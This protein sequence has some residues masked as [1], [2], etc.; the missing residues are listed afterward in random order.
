MTELEVIKPSED[1]V[2]IITEP[3]RFANLR[4]AA[5]IDQDVNLNQYTLIPNEGRW[6]LAPTAEH[7]R[8]LWADNGPVP[9]S[10]TAEDNICALT[11][12]P[13]N[14]VQSMPTNLQ[15]GVTVWA[16]REKLSREQNKLRLTTLSPNGH[17]NDWRL[18]AILSQR[19]N[20]IDDYQILGVFDEVLQDY[21][22][23]KLERWEIQDRFTRLSVTFDNIDLGDSEGRRGITLSNSEV[24]CASVSVDSFIWRLVCSNGL[25][26]KTKDTSYRFIHIGGKDNTENLR[27]AIYAS[28][29]NSESVIDAYRKATTIA[30]KDPAE[31]LRQFAITNKL[32]QRMLD[33]FSETFAMEERNT[34]SGIVNAI[35]RRAQAEQDELNRHNLEALAGKY[36]IDRVARIAS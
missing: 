15:T 23:A 10:R 4:A 28:L 9:L 12:M 29:Q 17:A 13:R 19:Y 30:L 34:V 11:G 26:A 24:G 14:W 3:L 22:G 2:S 7:K 8:G 16:M 32:S 5:A 18:R 20:P 35:T 6:F 31:E 1:Q 27:G 21:P 36:M 33:S 25:V